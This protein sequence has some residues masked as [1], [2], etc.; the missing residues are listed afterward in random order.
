MKNSFIK[1][2]CI[3][4]IA[5]LASCQQSNTGYKLSGEL[6]GADNGTKIA[7]VPFAMYDAK[8]EA[9]TTIENGKFS[10]EG[11]VPEPREYYLVLGN[12]EDYYRIMIENTS[13]KIKGKV[14]K[15]PGKEGAP[16]TSAFSEMEV[17][18]SKSNDYLYSQL[19]VRNELDS[20][21]NAIHKDFADVQALVAKASRAR[22]KALMDSITSLPRYAEFAKADKNFINT[23]EKRYNEVF[24]ANKET[25]WGPLLM[26]NLYSYLTPDARPT[27]ENMSKEARESYYGKMVAEDLY[28]ANRTGEKVPGFTTI[29]ING[30]QV[31]LNDLIKDKKVILIDFWASWC[32]PCRK[33]LP[34]VKAN[35]EKYAP[36]GFEV[37][38][39]SIDKD[40]KAWKKAVAEENL[41]WPNFNDL[42]IST[43]YKVKAVPTIYLID[44]QGRLIAED[45]RGE[46]L[47]KKL[48]EL[49]GD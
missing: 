38:S 6:T 1:V 28:P 11:E 23:V 2:W 15:H 33:E 40:P 17:S 13:I 43:L 5:F 25:S 41:K 26:L 46:K 45:I 37:L 7:L 8:A 9:E 18:G 42:N 32:A 21:Y 14:V 22:N 35:Y 4:L 20:M 16:E 44:N 19:D 30:N 27:F 36:K 47:G 48:E 39:F 24:D 49:L 12:K 34:N 31:S 10:F 3:V 29:D